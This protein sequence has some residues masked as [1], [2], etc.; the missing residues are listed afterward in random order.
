MNKHLRFTENG[1]LT[2]IDGIETDLAT[3][4]QAFVD[5]FPLSEKRQLLFHNYLEYLRLFS[6]KITPHFE[7]WVNGSF[8]T[9][10]ENPN[11]IDFVTF[12]DAAIFER[13][14]AK[15]EEFWSFSLEDEGLDA[16]IVK[17]YPPDSPLFVTHTEHFKQVWFKRFCRTKIDKDLDIATKG[18]I[19]LKFNKS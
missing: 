11:D 3:F 17:M 18:F 16:Y 2:P 10:K 9:K 4:K 1:Y 7:Q 19:K 5:N 13:N 8:V 14:E 12:I 15:L 6:K